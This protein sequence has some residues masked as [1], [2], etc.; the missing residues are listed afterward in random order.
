MKGTVTVKTLHFMNKLTCGWTEN[1]R[2][3]V[4]HGFRSQRYSLALL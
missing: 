4:R 1:I 3:R 2:A